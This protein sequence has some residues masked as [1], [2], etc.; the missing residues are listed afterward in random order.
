MKEKLR[1]KHNSLNILPTI[2]EEDEIKRNAV[3]NKDESKPTFKLIIHKNKNFDYETNEALDI[4]NSH[5]LNYIKNMIEKQA[6]IVET[7]SQK[8]LE[9]RKREIVV[10]IHDAWIDK[11]IENICFIEISDRIELIN[12]RFVK[13]FNHTI[14]II[15]KPVN[16]TQ[17]QMDFFGLCWI[18]HFETNIVPN[19]S[20]T[21]E[22]GEGMNAIVSLQGWKYFLCMQ[23]GIEFYEAI[24]N[25]KTMYNLYSKYDIPF[26]LEDIHVVSKEFGLILYPLQE[27]IRKTPEHIEYFSY[28]SKVL[29]ETITL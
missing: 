11:Y 20:N 5:R 18:Y 29:P 17:I 19:S 27:T 14:V 26:T 23:I 9:S 3:K 4:V 7:M 15:D 10:C 22:P 6:K 8:E 21:I 13:F 12:S 24:K 2:K 16:Q 28:W 1:R 25:N